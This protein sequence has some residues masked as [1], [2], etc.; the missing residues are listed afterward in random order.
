MTTTLAHYTIK[1]ISKKDT[2]EKPVLN[3]PVISDAIKIIDS[4]Q[5]KDFKDQTFGG[6]K[7][8]QAS[9]ALDKAIL[10]DKI[11]PAL[12][13][14]LQLFLSGIMNPLWSKFL[15]IASK[16]INIYNPKL[17]EFLY[18][19]NKQWD[20]LVDNGKFT[21]DNILLLRNHPSVRLLLAEIV[22]VLCLSRKR[23]INQ[24]PRIKKEEFII[25][26]FKSKLEAKDNRL[27]EDICIDGDPSEIRIAV[28]ELA[29]H[30]FN[31]KSNKALYW[32][33]WI[34]EW[35]KINSKKYGKYECGM[36]A[37]EGVDGKYFKD[38]VWLIWGVINK[39]R[40]NKFNISLAL[41]M[42]NNDINTQVQYLYMMYISKFTPGARSKKQN[43]II[44][45]ILYMT[46]T[47]DNAVA[48]VDRPQILFQSML[49][50]DK[51]VMNLKSQEVHHVVNNDLVNVVVENNYMK[52]ETYKELEARQLALKKD[53][54]RQEQEII[55]KK[56]NLN[57][58]SMVKL[59]DMYKLDR[60][61][62]S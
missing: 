31:G 55:A 16:S 40:Q 39:I 8:S 38:V 29:M 52:P 13:W 34:I 54:E 42:G 53:K 62:Y 56:K 25:D 30:I 14:T 22:S 44:W 15:S 24:L 45:A 2:D 59:N 33:N 58:Q 21:K 57:V 41:G 26:N 48:L 17:P 49:G 27:I 20:A 9:T 10:E 46:E 1:P 36:R 32:L 61:M 23:K 3:I 19:K 43:L 11:E 18:N 51:I 37:I 12:H 50:M 47:I 28:N 5:I 6:Y 7:L 60:M 35:E 4:R